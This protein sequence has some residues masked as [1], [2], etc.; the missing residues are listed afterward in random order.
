MCCSATG[1]ETPSGLGDETIPE[2]Q[3]PAGQSFTDQT[4]YELEE[5]RWN[6]IDRGNG[7]TRRKNLFRYHFVHNK[8]HMN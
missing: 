3:S 2:L 6:Y 1:E 4:I 5:P 7:R 8:S